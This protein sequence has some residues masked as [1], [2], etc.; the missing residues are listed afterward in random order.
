MTKGLIALIILALIGVFGT[1]QSTRFYLYYF[2]GL[3]VCFIPLEMLL[4]QSVGTEPIQML[5]LRSSWSYGNI[6]IF[7][8]YLVIVIGIFGIVRNLV[9]R[10]SHSPPSK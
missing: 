4:A 7:V 10:S 6:I 2:V 9:S 5:L 1:K 8:N 3:G